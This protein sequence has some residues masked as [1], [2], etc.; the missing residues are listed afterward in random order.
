MYS[1]LHF[2]KP[3]PAAAAAALVPA[4]VAGRDSWRMYWQ[5]ICQESA[6]GAAVAA[7]LRQEGGLRKVG[8]DGR[9]AAARSQGGMGGTGE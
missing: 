3:S 6:P 9:G 1:E 4:A 8:A 2:R 5:M 7:G